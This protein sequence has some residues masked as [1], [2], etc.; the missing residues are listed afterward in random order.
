MH[1]RLSVHQ[2]CTNCNPDLNTKNLNL[3]KI[4]KFIPVAMTKRKDFNRIMV[5][6]MEARYRRIEETLTFN[7]YI[8]LQNSKVCHSFNSIHLPQSLSHKS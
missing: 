4:E 2:S 3:G 1:L 7:V 6:I 8:Q 5:I